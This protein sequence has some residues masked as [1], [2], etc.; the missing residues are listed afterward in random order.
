MRL[1]K[2]IQ[3][4][5]IFST[6]TD[7]GRLTDAQ[8]RTVDFRYVILVMTSNL[9]QDRIQQL[10]D[11]DFTVVKSSVMDEVRAHFKLELLNNR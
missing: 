10:I 1:K 2:H 7:D 4:F 9:G 8:G 3:I 5:L 6:S 11:E